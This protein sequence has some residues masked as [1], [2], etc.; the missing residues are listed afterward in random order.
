MTRINVFE[1]LGTPNAILHPFGMQVY[2]QA[3]QALTEHQQV[4]I[5]MKGIKNATSAFFHA[6]VG[7][8]FRDLGS[9]FSA[10]VKVVG[11]EKRP[12][13]QE[14]ISDSIELVKNPKRQTETQLE[15]A[16]LFED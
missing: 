9:E 1:L 16:A 3:K 7:N 5:D 2:Q 12:D 15:V 10:R 13:W 11:I 14:R 6:S 8:L 4:T